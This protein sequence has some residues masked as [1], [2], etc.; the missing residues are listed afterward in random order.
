MSTGPGPDTVRA[1]IIDTA[2]T[3]ITTGGAE[4]VSLRP[5]MSELSLTTGAFYRCFPG[6]REALLNA[7]ARTASQRVLEQLPDAEALDALTPRDALQELGRGLI[8]QMS[9]QSR[10]LEFVLSYPLADDE[11]PYP[12]AQRTWTTVE[13]AASARGR[14]GRLLFTQVWAFICGLEQLTRLGLVPDPESLMSATLTALLSG[15]EPAQSPE[16]APSSK[17]DQYP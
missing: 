16:P 4:Q 9:G 15:D 2:L 6:G 10:L 8:E 13:R 3:Q 12:L 1:A 5:L 17:E 11:G 14:D 7:V